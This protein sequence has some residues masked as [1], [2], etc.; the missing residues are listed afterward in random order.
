MLDDL[1]GRTELKNQIREIEAE[2]DRL[3]AELDA[4]TERRADAVSARQAAEEQINRLEDRIAGLEGQLDTQPET[5]ALSYR[6]EETLRGDRLGTV[7]TRLESYTGDDESILTAYITD[8][9]PEAITDQFGDHTPLIT[10]AAPCLIITDDAGLLAV[11]LRPPLPPEPFLDWRET[12]HIDRA[13][14][15]PHGRYALSLIRADTFAH[16]IY[17]GPERVDFDGFQS[18][19]KSDHSKG[20]FSQARFE[21]RRDD[22]IADHL[23]RCRDVLTSTDVDHQYIVGDDRLI[24]EF[25]TIADATTAV[26]A[27]GDPKQALHDAFDAFWRVPLYSV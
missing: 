14:F 19:V 27:T 1:L 16:G 5:T 2:R 17:E 22:Q 20:G 24:G 11:A 4:E 3:K 10:R 13:W 7:L 6:H 25:D 15:Q 26:D 18:D 23:D 8:T 9:I 12:P 21:R